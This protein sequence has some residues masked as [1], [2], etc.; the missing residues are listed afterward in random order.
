MTYTKEAREGSYLWDVFA[1][2]EWIACFDYET[3]ADLFIR[4]KRINDILTS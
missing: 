4:F 2:D 1:D 3:D